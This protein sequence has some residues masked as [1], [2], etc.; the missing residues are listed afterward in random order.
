MSPGTASAAPYLFDARSVTWRRTS[1]WER[2]ARELAQRLAVDPLVRVRSAGSERLRSRVWQ[3]LAATPMATRSVRVAHFPTLP[4]V[5]WIPA[6]QTVFTLHDLT[7]WRY[8]ETA[9]A[10]GRHYYARLAALAARGRVHLVVDSGAVR[11][12]IVEEFG[13]DPSTVTVVP[14]GVDLPAAA[15]VPTRPRPYVLAVGTAE[16][17]KN[18]GRLV[19]AYARSGLAAS[20]DLVLVGRLGWGKIPSGVV[21]VTDVDDGQLVSTYRDATA[22]VLPSL[23]EGFGLPAVEALR[24]GTPVLCSDLPVLREVT[25]GRASYFDPADIDEMAAALAAA[26]EL[27]PHPGAAEW[28]RATYSWDAAAATLL[29]LYRT[30][31][32][33]N[34]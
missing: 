16:P 4:P 9:S 30:L 10:L 5:P 34:V 29:G 12:E 26:P 25:G 11:D 21:P 23:Y 14:L 27:T 17:R 13:R 8:R 32:E 20:H 33:A 6:G 31:D 28:A 18:L 19:E 2:Y 3:D 1:G 15:P 24:L 7:W 22:L